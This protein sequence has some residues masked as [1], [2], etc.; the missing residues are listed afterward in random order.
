MKLFVFI[1][2]YKN[3]KWM[4]VFLDTSFNTRKL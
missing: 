4:E 1:A 3:I 2:K